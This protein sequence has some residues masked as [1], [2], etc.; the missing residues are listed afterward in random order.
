MR[1]TIAHFLVIALSFG[2]LSGFATAPM[3]EASVFDF[4]PPIDGLSVSV[5]GTSALEV[6]GF[7]ETGWGPWEP[8]VLENEQDPSLR[9]SNLVMFPSLVRSVE[10]RGQEPMEI[11]PIRISNA[12]VKYSVAALND[13]IH[14]ILS[15]SEWGADESLRVKSVT[16]S[17]G[18]SS[19]SSLSSTVESTESATE[20]PRVKECNEAYAKYPDE[21][22]K[23]STVHKT[24]NGKKLLWPE[25][26]SKDIRMLVV[27]HTAG[28]NGA[29]T[30]SGLEMMRALYQYHTSNRGWG[31]IGYHYMIDPEGQIYEGRAGG[32]YVI[33]GHAYCNNVG[34]IGI[35]LMGNFDIEQP[36]RAQGQS[37]QWLLK[38]LSEKYH[39][40]TTRE[41]VFHG[42]QTPTIVGHRDLLSTDCPG[43]TMW[44]ALDQVRS[45]IR[46]G[47]PDLELVFRM[48][49]EVAPPLPT[50]KP[51]TPE[52]LKTTIVTASD[53]L[54]PLGNTTLDVRPGSEVIVPVYFRAPRDIAKNSRIARVVRTTGVVISQE[55]GEKY[56]SVRG[57]LRAPEKVKKGQAI[58]LRVKVKV[59]MERGTMALRIGSI[60]YALE[61]SGKTIRT[62]EVSSTPSTWTRTQENPVLNTRVT[63]R[64]TLTSSSSSVISSSALSPVI[65]IRLTQ[66]ISGGSISLQADGGA[67]SVNADGKAGGMEN[68]GLS[69][70]DGQCVAQGVDRLEGSVIRF[71]SGNGI[72]RI[73]GLAQAS[74]A[75]RGIIE[76]RVINGALTLINELPLEEYMAGIAEEPDTEPYEKQRAFAIAART[77]AKYYMESA[78]RKFPGKPYDGSDSPAEFQMYR[79]MG[80][81]EDNP[82]WVSAVRNTANKVLTY[83]GQIIKPP[84]FSENDGRTRSP[85]EAG[86]NNYPFA[87]IF[88]SKQDGWCKGGTLRGHGV[89]MSGCGA[90]GQANEGKTAEQILSYYYPGTDITSAK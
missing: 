62:R 74:R 56:V 53:G 72:V 34:T 36:T 11:H 13:G 84:Y 5:Q 4:D 23:S 54:A 42:K 44:S 90:E 47:R 19:S 86:W 89:G 6:R 29:E 8:L 60:A 79:G 77:Y 21:F 28:R 3:E 66:E 59:P 69:M 50:T 35:A 7:L 25:E 49:I 46:E 57:D 55:M 81:E 68:A 61:A 37:L 17:P 18:S 10:F 24:L 45:H 63:R 22:A 33:A 40:N 78:N 52:E 27:H 43:Y 41:T 14:R 51:L 80:L 83:R 71:S 39:I 20:S 30:R 48:P 31:D 2:A 87:D 73:T 1:Q 85:A 32:D 26:Y 67:L 70:Q 65:R 58:M 88:A 12:P 38:T 15:R 76:C 9:E 64:V 82:R 16:T 75:Y